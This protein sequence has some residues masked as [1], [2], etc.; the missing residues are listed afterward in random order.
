MGDQSL[1][2][3]D[4]VTNSDGT[5]IFDIPQDGTCRGKA[6]KEG[7]IDNNFEFEVSCNNVPNCL[8][9]HL[10]VL[11]PDLHPEQTR[12]MMTWNDKPNDMD[13]HVMAVK[14]SD[15]STCRTYYSRKNSCHK[16]SLDVDNTQ[17]GQ[18]GAETITLEDNAINQQ[19]VY[20]IGVE[21]YRFDN[22]G[23]KDFA[24]SRAAITLT[25]GIKTGQH[26]MPSNLQ[27]PNKR[28]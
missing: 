26:Q 15:K 19:Y 13:L 25:N 16:I 6:S 8:F 12:I 7:F 3:E 28:M 1:V 11:S 17:G 9:E 18:N 23:G 2:N 24:N 21:D 5:K 20:I 10:I 22:N 4:E 27:K 14:K